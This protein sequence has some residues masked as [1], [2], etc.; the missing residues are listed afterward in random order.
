MIEESSKV[1]V[2]FPSHPQKAEIEKINIVLEHLEPMAWHSS[3]DHNGSEMIK[4]VAVLEW[5]FKSWQPFMFLK[6]VKYYF[7]DDT[8]FMILYCIVTTSWQFGVFI[9][10]I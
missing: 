3:S 6:A 1:V 4:D 2:S 9:Y 7:T 5:N 8:Y 10:D